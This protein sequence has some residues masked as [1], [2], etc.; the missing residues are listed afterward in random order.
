[1]KNQHARFIAGLAILT[2]YLR[3]GKRGLNVAASIKKPNEKAMPGARESFVET[4]PVSEPSAEQ[5]ALAHF[6]KLKAD[7]ITNGWTEKVKPVKKDRVKKDRNA[8]MTIPSA[9]DMPAAVAEPITEVPIEIVVTTEE[10]PATPAKTRNGRGKADK[11]A[12][13]A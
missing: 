8:F 3:A 10:V 2:V 6:E 1:M 13:A 9:A 5:R 11:V 12:A 4:D 7:A